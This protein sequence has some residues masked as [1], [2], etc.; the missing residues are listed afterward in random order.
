MNR[1]S[2]VLQTSIRLKG[3]RIAGAEDRQG[4]IPG[5]I[6]AALSGATVVGIGAGGLMSH[7]LPTLC[8][9]GIGG[10]VLFD[11]DFV[12]ASNLN[13]QRFYEKDFGKNKALALAA[14]SPAGVH[15]CNRHPRIRI[16][17]GRSH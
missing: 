11:D 16:P 1:T 6:Q 4:K 3:K 17:A 10:L 9:K 14:K 2:S 7:I 12:E 5:F 15:R 8:R 13:R